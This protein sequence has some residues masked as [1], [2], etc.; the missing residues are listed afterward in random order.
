MGSGVEISAEAYEYCQQ[1]LVDE[2]TFGTFSLFPSLD[3]CPGT[4]ELVI[5]INV[6]EHIFD[7]RLFLSLILRKLAPGGLLIIGVPGRDDRWYLEDEIVGHLRR[8]SK[9]GLRFLIEEQTSSK[10]E[11]W[12]IGYPLINIGQ[13]VK[14][15]L[16]K[17]QASRYS[18]LTKDEQTMTSGIRTV[19]FFKLLSIMDRIFEIAINILFGPLQRFFYN[20]NA[21]I[22]LVAFTRSR[23]NDDCT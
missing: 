4:F 19:P 1:I 16:L 14:N 9:E 11:I 23:N 2:I 3:E 20:S 22:Q 18:A 7:D 12:S 17:R 13:R 15:I 21:G 10:T 5:C 6:L 8:Y